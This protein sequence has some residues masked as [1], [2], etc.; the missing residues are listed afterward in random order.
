MKRLSW[1]LAACYFYSSASYS[2]EVFG[3]TNNAAQFGLNSTPLPTASLPPGQR[4][5]AVPEP[6]LELREVTAVPL[7][8]LSAQVQR[9]LRSG[10]G[11]PV[12]LHL[13]PLNFVFLLHPLLLHA[14]VFGIPAGIISTSQ[15]QSDINEAHYAQHN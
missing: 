15:Q 13:L 12:L 7:R 5:L 9:P 8:P 10:Q 14:I 1:V 11:L 2:E 3:T 4:L 6:H